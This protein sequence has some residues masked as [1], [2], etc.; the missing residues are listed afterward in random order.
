[1]DNY[2]ITGKNIFAQSVKASRVSLT[3]NNSINHLGRGRTF[4]VVCIIYDNRNKKNR[5]GNKS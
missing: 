4:I 3:I 2:N 1:M 5:K